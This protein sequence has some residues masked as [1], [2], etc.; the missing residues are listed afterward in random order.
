MTNE[1]V[2]QEAIAFLKWAVD[3]YSDTYEGFTVT[4]QIGQE[5]Y[6]WEKSEQITLSKLYDIYLKS[7]QP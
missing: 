1:T 2:K 4:S 7:K 3:N 6:I 5:D